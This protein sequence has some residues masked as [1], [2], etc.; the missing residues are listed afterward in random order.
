MFAIFG[1]PGGPRASECHDLGLL[2]VGKALQVVGSGLPVQMQRRAR[3]ANRA[4][5]LA[6]E[7]RQTGE[8]VFDAGAWRGDTLVASLLRP[9]QRLVLAASP[10]RFVYG[11][12][13]RH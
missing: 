8:D 1:G 7:L 2:Q 4:Q 6:A 13:V 5:H 9:G 11:S 3:Q 12:I 10:P